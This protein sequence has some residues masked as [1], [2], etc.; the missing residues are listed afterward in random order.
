MSLSIAQ[1]ASCAIPYIFQPVL[2]GD[3]PQLYADGGVKDRLGLADWAR[4]SD[5]KT[6]IVHLV[7]SSR[8]GSESEVPRAPDGRRLLC[9]RTP[10]AD[11]SFL[12]LKD[13]EGQRKEAR[14]LTFDALRR[15]GSS[16]SGF[17]Y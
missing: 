13:Y 6:A 4:W 3:P 2:T 14:S 5:T 12:S 1:A 7:G 15:Q 10:K 8:P 9:V 11:A 17:Q 16:G